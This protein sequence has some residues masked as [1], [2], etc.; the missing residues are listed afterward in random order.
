MSSDR[1]F[2]AATTIPTA[3]RNIEHAYQLG[4]SP[5]SKQV[6]ILILDLIKIKGGARVAKGYM[7][8]TT[9]KSLVD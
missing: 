4:Y 6:N 2:P 5:D 1:L 9:T 7:K 8:P 3:I